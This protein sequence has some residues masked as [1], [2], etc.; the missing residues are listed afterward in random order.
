MARKKKENEETGEVKPIEVKLSKELQVHNDFD[1]PAS[2][3]DTNLLKKEDFEFLKIHSD[4]F[5]QRFRARSFFRSRFEM[6]ASVLNEDVHPTPDSKY[7]QAIGE[8]NVHLTEL[9]SLSYNTK[10]LTKDI[11]L[12]EIDIDELKFKLDKLKRERNIISITIVGAPIKLSNE[13]MEENV[14]SIDRCNELDIEIRRVE[15]QIE[16]AAIEYEEMCFNLKQGNK[17]AQERMREVREWEPIIERLHEQL[18]FGDEDFQLHHPRRYFERYARKVKRL[19]ILTPEE[20]ESAVSHFLSFAGHPENKERGRSFIGELITKD[21]MSPQHGLIQNL[22]ERVGQP[23]ALLI[24]NNVDKN[25]QNRQIAMQDDPVVKNF[26]NR[27][28]LKIL[29]CSPHRA[30]GDKMA[31]NIFS[32]Q[33]PAAFECRLWEPH[34]MSVAEARNSSIRKAKAEGFNYIFWI[35][36]DTI[37]PR[38]ALVQLIS[39][40]ADIVGGFYY[41]KYVPLESVGMREVLVEGN[42]K[43]PSR[44]R[45]YKVGDILHNTLVLPSGITLIKLDVFD[46]IPEPWYTT[47]LIESA[48]AITED[49]YFCQK[50]RDAGYDII[51]DTGVQGI[52]VDM[53]SNKIFGHPDFVDMEHNAILNPDHFCLY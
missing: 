38:N 14:V 45:N 20:K 46:K 37:V 25:Y 6:E 8:Q 33:T 19:D 1:V 42:R 26:F 5:E 49:T 18:E 27:D 2:L 23:D 35:D 10:K 41:R 34:G 51:T 13:K 39:H 50:A 32:L 30:P 31:T 43:V 21:R 48:P 24:G 53:A 17:V 40:D 44:I 29:V 12:K 36:D 9:I 52:H 47:V 15:R 28:V 11:E 4:Q 16:K 22:T 3:H 7:F